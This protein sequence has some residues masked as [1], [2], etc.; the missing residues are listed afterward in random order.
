MPQFLENRLRAEARKRG[1]TGKRAERYTFGAMNNIG[2]MRGNKET[3]K[4]KRMERKHKRD[5]R[6]RSR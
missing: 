2:A 4:G 3:A 6:N 1:Y 5:M